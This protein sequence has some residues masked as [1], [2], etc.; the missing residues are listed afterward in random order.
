MFFL[1]Y[2]R[3]GI[4]LP[5]TTRI[6]PDRVYFCPKRPELYQIGYTFTHIVFWVDFHRKSK[7]LRNT[8]EIDYLP[9][10]QVTLPDDTPKS[11]KRTKNRQKQAI[12]TQ[13]TPRCRE[14]HRH[15]SFALINN[16]RLSSF[17][18]RYVYIHQIL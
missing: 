7:K 1:F 9:S 15:R 8:P 12:A 10:K 18:W 4:L 2:T 17:R 16:E 13:L 5:K 3:S 14:S 11:L 6:I